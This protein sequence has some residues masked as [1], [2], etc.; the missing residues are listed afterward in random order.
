M[1]K[2]IVGVGVKPDPGTPHH[3]RSIEA[4]H[5]D[6]SLAMRNVKTPTGSALMRYE[7][8]REPIGL[9]KGSVGVGMPNKRRPPAANEKGNP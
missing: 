9:L 4:T 7:T 1:D 2:S 6:G 3:P 8:V 5:P